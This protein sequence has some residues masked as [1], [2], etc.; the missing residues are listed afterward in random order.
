MINTVIV[1]TLYVGYYFVSKPFLRKLSSSA[2][3]SSLPILTSATIAERQATFQMSLV[4]AAHLI[5][6]CILS[7]LVLPPQW[8]LHQTSH[9][10]FQSV[11]VLLAM[12]LGIGESVASGVLAEML[13]G[14]LGWI[15]RRREQLVR[16]SRLAADMVEASAGGWMKTIRGAVEANLIMGGTLL[17]MQLACEEIISDSSSPA[18]CRGTCGPLGPYSSSCSS[19]V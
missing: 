15:D 6:V 5:M 19:A 9:L 16:P 1:V 13:Y 12:L 14:L 11:A 2:A 10:G 18:A 3:R 8:W 4:V 17:T 7:F